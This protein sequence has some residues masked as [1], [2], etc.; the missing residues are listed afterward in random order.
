MLHRDFEEKRKAIFQQQAEAFLAKCNPA[1]GLIHSIKHQSR[2]ISMHSRASGYDIRATAEAATVW[3]FCGQEKKACQALEMVL[4]NQDCNPDSSTW[5]NFKWHSDWDMALDPNAAAFIVPHLW[6]LYKQAGDKLP[7]TLQKR[8]K[9]T[10]RMAYDGIMAHCCTFLYTNIVLLNQASLLCIADVLDWPRPRQVVGW[11][12]EEWRNRICHLGVFPEYNSLTYGAVDIHALAIM[13]ACP[14]QPGLHAE[15]R[16]LMRLLLAQAI[17]DRH[18]VIGR[19]TGPQSRAYPADRRY[20]GC[21]GMDMILHFVLPQSHEC[22]HFFSWLGVPIGEEDILPE[23][24]QLPLPRTIRACAAGQSRQNYLGKDFALGSIDGRGHWTGHSLPFFLAYSSS[25]RR[26]GI[27]ILPQEAAKVEVHN[28]N[29]QEGTLLASCCWLKQRSVDSSCGTRNFSGLN[30]GTPDNLLDA[31]FCPGFTI[32]LDRVNE[33]LE[34]FDAS[35]S[36]LQSGLLPGEILI[37]KTGTLLIA[38]RFLSPYGCTKLS[39]E[40]DEEGERMLEVTGP[41]CGLPVSDLE[42]AV[43]LAFL[44][45]VIPKETMSIPELGAAMLTGYCNIQTETCGWQLN[46]CSPAGKNLHIQINP[47]PAYFWDFPGSRL[48]ANAL[49]QK[50]QSAQ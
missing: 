17:A 43:P 8:L 29:Q 23:V 12:F 1:D 3:M 22:N 46:C 19:I 34:L 21:S 9:E 33:R 27:P 36:P 2:D 28:A 47:Q 6:Y 26:C 15:I 18:P 5:G 11:A 32:E 45:E 31:L 4:N 35:G 16:T 14:A 24:R 39:L 13:L 48:N 38:L 44:L 50:M 37:I 25:K 40:E 42:E 7:E 20:R 30:T 41:G 10:L 49:A